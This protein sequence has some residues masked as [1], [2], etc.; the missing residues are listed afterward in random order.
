VDWR[1]VMNSQVALFD[2]ATPGT[3]PR[4]NWECV[5]L[6]LRAALIFN[7]TTIAPRLL[8]DRKHYDYWDLPAGYQ[9]TQ[10][11]QPLA[12]NG[13]VTLNSSHNINIR[14]RQIHLEQVKQTI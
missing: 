6:A 4:L 11:R 1:A 3:M 5:K 14:I 13:H 7:C 10:H 8:F 9:I 12:K 2:S